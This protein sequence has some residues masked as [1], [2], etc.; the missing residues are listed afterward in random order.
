[1]LTCH[2]AAGPAQPEMTQSCPPL[3]LIWMVQMGSMETVCARL[4]SPGRRSRIVLLKMV[5]HS[6]A[7]AA[8]L[9][10]LL[11][12]PAGTLAWPQAWVFMAL[13]IGLLEPISCRARR[14]PGAPR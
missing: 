9:G 12:L 4:Q 14:P 8:L 13:F 11:F 5:A 2:A 1:M 7:F 6:L 3:S 10:L